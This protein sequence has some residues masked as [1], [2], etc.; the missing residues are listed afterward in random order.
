M[1]KEIMIRY[2]LFN[3]RDVGGRYAS[4]YELLVDFMNENHITKEAVV[5]IVSNERDFGN[6]VTLIWEEK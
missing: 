6:T 2:K 4:S 5:T 1:G 3:G